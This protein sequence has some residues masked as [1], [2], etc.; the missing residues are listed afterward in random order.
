[1]Y[2]YRQLNPASAHKKNLEIMT[3]L[4]RTI[5]LVIYKN[6]TQSNM[7]KTLKM[8]MASPVKYKPYMKISHQDQAC[9]NI[10]YPSS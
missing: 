2:N 6:W 8:R 3:E 7:Y 1:M 5:L 9:S 10:I 4:E